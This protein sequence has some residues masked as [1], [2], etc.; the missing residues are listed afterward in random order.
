MAHEGRSNKVSDEA[1]LILISEHIASRTT[2]DS[3]YLTFA[4]FTNVDRFFADFL[5]S[6]YQLELTSS[7]SSCYDHF[8]RF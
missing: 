3:V 4:D 7:A 6:F 2:I 8:L 1:P 5:A